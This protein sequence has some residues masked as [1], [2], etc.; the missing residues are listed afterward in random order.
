[1]PD[2]INLMPILEG[3]T[4]AS[5]RTLFF[6]FTIGTTKQ[7]AVRQGSWKLLVDG[8]KRYVFD[9]SKDI[10]ERNDLARQRQDIARR[11]R[12]LIGAWEA[13]VDAEASANAARE[14]TSR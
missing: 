4:D 1:M 11:L 12:P 14:T 5:E 3:R 7:V 13:D 8:A 9:L 10:G 6:R 2:G